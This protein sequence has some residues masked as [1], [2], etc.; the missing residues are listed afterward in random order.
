M[1]IEEINAKLRIMDNALGRII[2]SGSLNAM[3]PFNVTLEE[4]KEAICGNYVGV[5]KK[6]PTFTGHLHVDEDLVYL[7]D[8]VTK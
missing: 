6:A 1:S 4:V 7:L 8:F 2:K 5:V 3:Y